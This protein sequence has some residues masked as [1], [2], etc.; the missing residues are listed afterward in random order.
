M[1]GEKKLL[2]DKEMEDFIKNG[3]VTLQSD[4]PASFHSNIYKKV[5]EMFEKHGNLGNNILPLVPDIQKIFDQPIVHG[6]MTS[7]LGPNYVMHPHRYCHLNHPGSEGQGFHK[8]SYEGDEQVRH[9][10]CRWTMA[11]Y[12]PQD[13]TLDMGPTA[14]LPGTQYYDTHE[15]AHS[16]P[17]LPLCGEAGTL[18]IVHYDLWHR[19]MPNHS[20]KQRY[21]VKFLFIRLEDP[22]EP[23]WNNGQEKWKSAHNENSDNKHQF[24][25][26]KFW[27]WYRG[28]PNGSIGNIKSKS[29]NTS[30]LIQTLQDGTQDEALRLEAAYILG[31]TRP[32]VVPTLIEMLC[33][34]SE[35]VSRYATFALGASGN[36]AIPE[37]VKALNNT[38]ESVRANA[39]F[40]LGDIGRSAQEAAPKLTQLL[41]DKSEWVRRHAS[42]ALGI[43]NHPNEETISALSLLLQDK[44]YWVRDNAARALAKLGASAEPAI[45]ALIPVLNDENRYVRFHA[46]LA[47]KQIGTPTATN[48]LFD[49]LL[50]SRWCPL[51]NNNSAY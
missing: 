14:V 9:P 21:M 42:E 45:P 22:K 46:A 34:D 23:S 24:M 3:Y 43:I 18:T 16:Q 26:S 15:T 6:A 41:K 36:S 1:V 17:E 10:H 37:L 11:F 13:T 7:I 28:E 35:D 39:A 40:A 2:N 33:D 50:T 8:D 4:L 32:S 19:A 20:Q 30:K 38:N 29:E 47:L 5:E 31:N 48:I 27:N 44:H 12:Y 49:H 25:W 51:T